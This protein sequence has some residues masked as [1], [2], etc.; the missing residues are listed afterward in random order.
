MPASAGG[1]RYARSSTPFSSLE[2][3]DPS[4]ILQRSFTPTPAAT[5][6]PQTASQ[7]AGLH[8]STSSTT[9]SQIPTPTSLR[10]PSPCFSQA[11]SFAGGSASY[12]RA[13]S[14][15]TPEPHLVAASARVSHVRLPYARPPPVPSLPFSH[16]A[17]RPP[18]RAT[19]SPPPTIEP[20]SYHPNPLDPLDVALAL[21]ISSLPLLLRVERLDAPLALDAAVVGSGMSA[22]YAITAAD[23]PR[24]SGSGGVVCKLVDRVGPRAEKG[25]TKVLVR[26]G[27]GWMELE[28]WA[29]QLLA[30]SV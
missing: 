27:T 14:S 20:G 12:P 30:K 16:R 1:G 23:Q 29:L 22:K 18:S 6:L 5:R 28:L 24:R 8:A 10:A 21:V 15:Q 9:R 25:Q 17:R 13:S 7:R 3:P 19:L 26:V 2:D 4:S 11:S